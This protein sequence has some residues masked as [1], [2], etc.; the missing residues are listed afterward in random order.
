MRAYPRLR[1]V[2]W[3]RADRFIPAAEAFSLY[4]RN[5]RF[6]DQ[7]ALTPDERAFIRRLADR[8]GKGVLNV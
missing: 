5:W 1:F 6:F 7:A 3:N 8:V 2:C 4:E